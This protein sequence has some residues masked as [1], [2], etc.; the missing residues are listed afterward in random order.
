M[1]IS[2][3]S[4]RELTM[5]VLAGIG[6]AGAA[7]L[8]WSLLLKK[9]PRARRRRRG[10]PEAENGAAP[11]DVLVVGAG[12][13]G[14]QAVRE[15]LDAGLTVRALEREATPGGKWSGHG[16]YDCVRIQQHREEFY[17]PGMPFAEGT[18]DFAAR[19]DVVGATDRYVAHY[20]LAP[21]L[22]VRADVTS[23]VWDEAARVWTTTT[24]A[25]RVWT[26]RFVAFAV[27]TLG[28]PNTPR[29]VTAAL[30]SFGGEATHSHDY[31]RP[32][33]YEGKHVAVLGFG[34]SGVEI[35]QDLAHN[36]ACA[37]VTMIAPPKVVSDPTGGGGATKREGQARTV[38]SPSHARPS[39][40]RHSHSGRPA[41]KRK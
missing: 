36:G 19:D 26:S 27:G 16:I 32:L 12:L 15:C 24:R 41:R 38:F 9:P 5:L 28:E 8:A 22:E 20:Q 39:G 13:S 14:L 1:A 37:S 31:Y 35:A 34:S 11:L 40:R 10:A 33:P 4:Q 25:G 30:A 29:Q 2:T 7:G 3:P 18:R 6:L 17:V 23:V 21:H